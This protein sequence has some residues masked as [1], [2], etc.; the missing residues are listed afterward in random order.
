MGKNRENYKKREYMQSKI[1]EVLHYVQQLNLDFYHLRNEEAKAKI[2]LA[3]VMLDDC[4]ETL[5][6]YMR[7]YEEV[8]NGKN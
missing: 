5:V 6:E 3:R 2:K 1:N 8:K 7:I 4:Y